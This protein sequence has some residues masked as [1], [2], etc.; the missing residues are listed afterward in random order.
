[1]VQDLS[2]QMNMEIK[3]RD[4]RLVSNRKYTKYNTSLGEMEKPN[5]VDGRVQKTKL[6]YN[7]V[8]LVM[9]LSSVNQNYTS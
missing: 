1:M 8:G 6:Y 2:R 4:L 9:L 3:N 7:Q 5:T